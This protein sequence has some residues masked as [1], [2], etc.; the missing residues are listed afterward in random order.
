MID[1]RYDTISARPYPSTTYQTLQ[2]TTASYVSD[3]ERIWIEGKSQ[4]KEWEPLFKY[5]GEYDHPMWK[6]S[7]KEASQTAHG[8]GDYFV[9]RE[10]IRALRS[11]GPPPVDAYDA[12]TWSSIIPLS[13][14]SLRG[15]SKPVEIPDF[16]R[17]KWKSRTG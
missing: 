13:A 10:F 3:G 8:G 4:K 9:I 16:T 1:L 7:E 12:A 5:S 11:G 6:E 14:E 17:G 2:G 15:K